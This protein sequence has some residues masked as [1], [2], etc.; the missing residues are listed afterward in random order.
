MRRL[1]LIVLIMT[2]CSFFEVQI[3]LAQQTSTPVAAGPEPALCTLSAPTI[4]E[5]QTLMQNPELLVAQTPTP[6]P[7]P[8]EMPRGFALFDDERLEVEKDL[9]RAVACFNT[10]NPL[11]VFSTYTDRYVF[12]IVTNLG[13]LDPDVIDGLTTIRRLDEEEYIRLLSIDDMVLL[14]DGRVAV[15]ATGYNPIDELPP[16]PRLFYLEEVLPGRWLIDEV[17]EMAEDQ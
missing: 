15:L 11:A 2:F 9:I 5:L 17:I 3:G 16:G 8:F 14:G 1:K 4:D 10:G 12:Q 7:D 6:L 13:G